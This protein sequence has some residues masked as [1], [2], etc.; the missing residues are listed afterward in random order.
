MP[1]RTS[2]TR[3]GQGPSEAVSTCRSPAR[4]P[5]NMRRKHPPRPVVLKVGLCGQGSGRAPMRFL[6]NGKIAGGKS[7]PMYL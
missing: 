3:E 5:R 7:Y 2:S 6:R 4:L 1:R